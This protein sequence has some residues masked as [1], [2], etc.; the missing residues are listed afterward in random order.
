M[1]RLLIIGVGAVVIVIFGYIYFLNSQKT[2]I[3]NSVSPTPA[4]VVTDSDT[5]DTLSLFYI[6]PDDNGISGKKIGCNDSLVKVTKEKG[7]AYT[8]RDALQELLVDKSEYYGDSGL[9][10][11]LSQ[12]D[13]QLQDVSVVNGIAT[14]LLTGTVKLG[15][16]CDS[17]RVVE[18]LQ[19][20]V[21]QFPHVQE[22]KIQV[23][24]IPLL[25]AINQ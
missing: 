21:L 20:T 4:V 19:E 25:D 6:A 1:I 16:V 18:Q 11:A 3:T 2:S 23:N 15:G 8:I 10:N 13:L 5:V 24:G 22:V 12:S 7:S 14:I 17:P 9:Y